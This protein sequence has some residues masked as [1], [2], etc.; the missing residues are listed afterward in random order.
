[1][2]ERSERLQPDL[3]QAFHMSIRHKYPRLSSPSKFLQLAVKTRHFPSHHLILF[4][5]HCSALPT[6]PATPTHPEHKTHLAKPL[7]IQPFIT[8]D[9]FPILT[10]Q[11]PAINK[12][13]F[14]HLDADGFPQE[15][16]VTEVSL[17]DTVKV[18]KYIKKKSLDELSK[19][20]VLLLSG[21]LK[22]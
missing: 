5:N 12:F 16:R 19:P 15:P 1:M 9:R 21:Y 3:T 8:R 2:K 6:H 14:H 17:T 18:F 13:I 20:I 7:P 10:E 11:G 4:I 22:R